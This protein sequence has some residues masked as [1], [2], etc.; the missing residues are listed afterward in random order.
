MKLLPW[1]A[2]ELT[3]L[4]FGFPHF[5][6]DPSDA[7]A[8]C[9]KLMLKTKKRRAEGGKRSDLERKAKRTLMGC[10]KCNHAN[11]DGVRNSSS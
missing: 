9:F 6:L 7:R 4:A 11:A 5:S 2:I 10:G 1:N 3:L 8:E